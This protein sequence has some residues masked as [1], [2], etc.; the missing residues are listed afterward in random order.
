MKKLFVVSD[1]HSFYTEMMTALKANGYDSENPDHIFASCGDLLDRGEFPTECLNFVNNLPNER[2]ILILGNHEDLM[3]EAIA[4][5]YFE[6]HDYHNGTID[7]AYR[8]TNY[9]QGDECEAAVLDEMRTNK[10]W[11]TYIKSCKNYAEVGGYIFV[12]GWI[13]VLPDTP[14]TGSMRMED[15]LE[16]YYHPKYKY[17]PKWRNAV[18]GDDWAEARWLNG[19]D[20]WNKGIREPDKTIVCGHF[21][22]SWGHSRLHNDGVE[23]LKPIETYYID[24]ETGNQEPHCRHDEFEDDGILAMDACTALS[25]IVNC[26]VLKISDEEWEKYLNENHN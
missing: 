15:F 2:K 23:W 17:N 19:M 16:L 20:M 24:P 9:N 13:P 1:V 8:L 7:T 25:H 3:E 10:P 5:H 4:R 18:W 14:D 12:H 26:R 22:T 21:H 6:N 11:N